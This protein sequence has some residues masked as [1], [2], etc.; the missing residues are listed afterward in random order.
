MSF[1]KK[2]TKEKLNNLLFFLTGFSLL[3]QTKLII[4]PDLLNY[5]EIS[6]FLPMIF[7][8]LLFI[9]N[10]NFFWANFKDYKKLSFVLYALIFLE[11]FILISLFFSVNLYLSFYKYLIFLLA[12]ILFLIIRKVN[13]KKKSA[14]IYG[15]LSASF[16]QAIIALAQFFKQ[17]SW[18]FKYLGLVKH[19][20][21]TLGTAVIETM[22]GRWLRAYGA[23]DHPNILGGICAISAII[24]AWYL[25]NGKNRNN[26]FFFLVY[27]FSLSALFFSFSRSA[28]LAFFIAKVLLLTYSLVLKNNYKKIIFIILA[29]IFLISPFI[30]TY[31]NLVSTRLLAQGRLEEKSKIERSLQIKENINLDLNKHFL[32]GQGFGAS[33]YLS[34]HNDLLNNKHK[35]VWNYQPV[36]NIFILLFLEIGIFGLVSF[37]FFIF[38]IIKN[39]IKKRNYFYGL[40][41]PFLAIFIVISF[42]DHWFFTLNSGLFSLF[43]FLGI[44]E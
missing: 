12:V 23:L 21:S 9:F 40:T 28:W 7:I 16:F 14:I 30:F 37:I 27:L 35:E 20:A 6:L 8:I 10:F 32:F 19:N 44:I 42:F 4:K 11:L 22:D 5:W 36:H 29:S 13:Y 41:I 34:Y 18:S 26:I 3:L 15:F 33:T 2:L 31:H 1:I 25:I 39:S 24:S 17:E 43:L 38:L